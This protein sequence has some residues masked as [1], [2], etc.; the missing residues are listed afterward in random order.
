M[1]YFGW[2]SE[3]LPEFSTCVESEVGS[4]QRQVHDRYMVVFVSELELA[5]FPM[6]LREMSTYNRCP[7]FLGDMV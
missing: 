5:W 7:Y 2:H 1:H 3:I 4:H 6:H